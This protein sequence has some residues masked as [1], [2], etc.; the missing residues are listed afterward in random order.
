MF[1]NVIIEETL[2]DRN[3]DL[4]VALVPA[5]RPLS[6][7]NDLDCCCNQ[8]ACNLDSQEAACYIYSNNAVRHIADNS[9]RRS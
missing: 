4:R 7:N 9:G 6:D 3:W 5:L 1:I 2:A 8:A